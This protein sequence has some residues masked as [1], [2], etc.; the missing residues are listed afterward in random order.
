VILTNLN[1]KIKGFLRSFS[2]KAMQI[3]VVYNVFVYRIISIGNRETSIQKERSFSTA[4]NNVFDRSGTENDPKV[5]L[6]N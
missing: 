1:L 4:I 5:L 6:S 3:N 2:S